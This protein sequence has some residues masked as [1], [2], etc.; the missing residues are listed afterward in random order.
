MES[1]IEMIEKI[2]DIIN[3]NCFPRDLLDTWRWPCCR[4]S[5]RDRSILC[6]RIRSVP[7]WPVCRDT[8][9]SRR[10]LSS[11]PRRSSA[12]LGAATSAP[13]AES[14]SCQCRAP[15]CRWA[16]RRCRRSDPPSSMPSRSRSWSR[17]CARSAAA[18]DARD[19][20]ASARPRA[21]TTRTSRRACGWRSYPECC[22]PEMKKNIDR[23]NYCNNINFFFLIILYK[24]FL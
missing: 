12:S 15:R 19:E 11:A 9:P 14:N 24:L 6:S 13:V 23:V 21:P 20:F 2:D 1:L 16:P 10:R 5:F 8:H 22:R 7:C 18:Q 4:D 3:S 17:S